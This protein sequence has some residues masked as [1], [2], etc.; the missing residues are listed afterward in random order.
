MVLRG[1][2]LVLTTLT[3]GLIAGLYYSFSVSVMPGFKRT[4]DR[5]MVTGMQGINV[6]IINGWFFL[7][8]LGSVILGIVSIFL[9][10]G[11]PVF[12]WV[13]VG[14]ILNVIQFLVTMAINVP[15]NNRLDAA[16]DRDVAG[17]RKAFEAAWTRWNLLR[18]LLCTAGFAFLTWAL[19]VLGQ[20]AH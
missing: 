5:T 11:T 2:F 13:L 6:A 16:G 3:T 9:N 17:T 8:F 19:V 18:T 20:T 10:L 14:V 4:D 1:I 12:V 7:S 15:L